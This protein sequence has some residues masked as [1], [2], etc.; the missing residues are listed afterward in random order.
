MSKCLRQTPEMH[1]PCG[2]CEGCLIPSPLSR[3]TRIEVIDQNGRAYSQ[4]GV[5]TVELSYQDDGRTLKVFVT[6]ALPDAPPPP[7]RTRE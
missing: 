7:G 1:G 6:P 4:W 2:L 5:Q 3:V